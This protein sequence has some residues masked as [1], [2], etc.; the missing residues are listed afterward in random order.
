M[1][2]VDLRR[3]IPYVAIRTRRL[4]KIYINTPQHLDYY[5][6]VSNFMAHF[7]SYSTSLCAG[8]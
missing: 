3:A 4:Q 8:P 5:V 2:V 7:I 6:Q 1:Y